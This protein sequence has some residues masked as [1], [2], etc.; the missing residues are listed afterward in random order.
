MQVADAL[1]AAASKGIIHRDIK[2]LNI[3]MTPRGQ[4]KVLDFGLAKI[5]APPTSQAEASRMET[6]AGTSPG[7]LIG[8]VQYMSP[9]QALGKPVDHR[10]EF[11][12]SVLFCINY[13]QDVFPFPE[14]LPVK[15]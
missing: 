7:M 6:A 5:E 9:E 10:S 13:P 14:K 12:R 4:I 11:I 2:S 3:M 8:T 1:D 15:Y